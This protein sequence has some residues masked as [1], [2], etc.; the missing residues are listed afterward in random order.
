[1]NALVDNPFHVL[2]LPSDCPRAEV[3]R[4]G[5]KLIG[6]LQLGLRAAAEYQTPLGS[7]PRTPE[8]VRH[9]MAELRSPERR[10][11]YELWAQKGP[12]E[13]RP[14]VEPPAAAQL[15]PFDAARALGWRRR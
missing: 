3:E 1:M 2:G 4:Q 9:A 7:R 13:A 12:V 14:P 15:A 11:L 10:L 5:Q 6:M 8:L